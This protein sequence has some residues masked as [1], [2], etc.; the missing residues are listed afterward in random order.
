GFPYLFLGTFSGALKALPRSGMWMVTVRKVFGLILIGMAIYFL[1]PLLGKWS[2]PVL[3]AYFA[4]S[5]AYLIL[6][7]AGRTKP[8]Q[9][10]WV[11]R[12]IGGG[13]RRWAGGLAL[14][15]NDARE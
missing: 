9:F 2:N 14:S 4:L 8:M 6:W 5:A 12:A 7:E 3:I 10:A 11:L 1:T 13:A 15:Q